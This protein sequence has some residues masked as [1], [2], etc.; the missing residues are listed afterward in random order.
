MIWVK[1]LGLSREAAANS[2]NPFSP[3]RPVQFGPD[4]TD[5]MCAL[6]LGV[7]PVNLEEVPL[8]AAAR[9]KKLREKIA[10][11]SPEQRARHN[12]GEVLER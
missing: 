9:E 4:A 7:I 2:A 10:E 6:Y 8:F 5:E 1:T 12:W 11:L 3:P